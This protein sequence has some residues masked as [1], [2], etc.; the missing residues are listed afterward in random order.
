MKKTFQ[1]KDISTKKVPNSFVRTI[2]RFQKQLQRE[3]NIN[4]GRKANKVS[5][6]FAADE[7]IKQ[8]RGFLK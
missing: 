5:F 8:T 4:K 2:E 6:L 3:E 1:A 7:Y